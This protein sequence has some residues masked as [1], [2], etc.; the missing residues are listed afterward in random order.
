M[1]APQVAC[2]EAFNAV[3]T[4]SL[5][6]RCYASLIA[7]HFGHEPQLE[8]LPWSQSATRVGAEYTAVTADHVERSP[9]HSMA[10]AERLLGFV[11]AHTASETVIEAAQWQA[12]QG[13]LD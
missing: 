11:P 12:D 1:E 10:M 5:T 2:G 13:L 7:R 6:L 9:H 3:A 4:E 8:F